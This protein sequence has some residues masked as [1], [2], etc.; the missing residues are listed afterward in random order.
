MGTF[1]WALR[2]G[3]IDADPSREIAATVDTGAAYTVLPA[4]LLVEL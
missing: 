1:E 3:R 2:V 4:S